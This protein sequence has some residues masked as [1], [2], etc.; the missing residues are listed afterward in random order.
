MTLESGA[1]SAS[2]DVVTYSLADGTGSQAWWHEA[3]RAMQI[4][5][6]T[7]TGEGQRNADLRLRGTCITSAPPCTGAQVDSIDST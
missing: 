6:S 4:G 2:M 5:G 7:S 1:S 3:K